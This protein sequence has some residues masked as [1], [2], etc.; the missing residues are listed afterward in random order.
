V[1]AVMY[2]RVSTKEQAE[3]GYSIAAQAEACRRFIADKGW[4]LVDEFIDRGESA[5]T[6][7][8][9]QFQLMLQRLGEESSVRYLVVHKLDRLA[10]NLEDHARVRAMLRKAGVQLISVTESIE[11]SASGKLVEGILASIAEFYSANLSQEIRKG[12]DQKASQ[13]GWPTVAPYGYRNIRREAG[14]RRGEAVLEPDEQAPLVVWAFEQYATGRFSLPELTK[15]VEAKGLRNRLGNP[16]RVSAVHRML[17][18]P[19]YTG[20]VVWKGVE[21]PGIHQPLI[22]R[23]LYDK[24]QSVMESHS[25]GGDRAW[26]HDHYLKNVLLLRRLRLTALLRGRQRPVRLLPVRR[27]QHSAE[28][29]RAKRLPPRPRPREGRRGDLRARAH[30][31]RTQ[32]RRREGPQAGGGREGEAQGRGDGVPGQAPQAAGQRAREAPEGLLR[33]RHR[34]RHAQAGAGSHQRGSGGGGGAA[35][36]RGRQAQEGN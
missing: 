10:R 21:Y 3:E 22:S 4:E 34:R 17:R 30:P 2:L 31:A 8:R 11:D 24:V 28:A 6:S 26:K 32:E 12:I 36:Q 35:V 16:P 7:D 13:G 15:A 18:N 9:P 27:P 29:V 5:R 19:I 25:T 23:D 1:K 14:G 33:R 20:V